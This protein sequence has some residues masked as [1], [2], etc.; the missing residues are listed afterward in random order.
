VT[1]AN[2]CGRCGRLVRG[3]VLIQGP[4]GVWVGTCCA[5][6]RERELMESLVPADAPE[7]VEPEASRTVADVIDVLSPPPSSRLGR[8]R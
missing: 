3:Y 8:L 7:P 1:V 5:P 2:R 4:D 6:Q